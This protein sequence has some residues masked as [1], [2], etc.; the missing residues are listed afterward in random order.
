V[1]EFEQTPHH[2]LD[3][4]RAGR[5]AE[6]YLAFQIRVG[7]EDAD[8]VKHDV[9]DNGFNQPIGGGSIVVHVSK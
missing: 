3:L 4:G 5:K 6:N 8:A 2:F 9:Y 7:W 1:F